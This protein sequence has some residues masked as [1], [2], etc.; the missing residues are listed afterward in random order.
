MTEHFEPYSPVDVERQIRRLMN[1]MTTA[2]KALSKA[3]EAEVDAEVAHKKARLRAAAEAPKARRGETTVSEREEWIDSHTEDEW[4]AL[5]FARRVRE[6]S[7]DSLRVL[8]DQ[9][10]AMQSLGASVRV[11]YS[12]AGV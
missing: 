2:Q 1:A 7:Q 9:L 12:V 11:A 3:R 6:D 8:R 5:L 10:S 4:A